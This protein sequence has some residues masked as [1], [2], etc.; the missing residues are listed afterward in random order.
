MFFFSSTHVQYKKAYIPIISVYLYLCEQ[1][2]YSYVPFVFNSRITIWTQKMN[3]IESR[4]VVVQGIFSLN[5]IYSFFF[6]SSYMWVHYTF[7]VYDMV[8][9][10]VHRRSY[11]YILCSSGGC[12][13]FCL[14][15]RHFFLNVIL[16]F[17]FF[18]EIIFFS[19][20]YLHCN[21]KFIISTHTC[22]R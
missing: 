6:G 20:K 15:F 10:Y 9:I 17:G 16:L 19:P 5:S 8:D 18:S 14:P 11:V 21:W 4:L 1:C 12:V 22:Q 13:K 7:C 2:G 3:I